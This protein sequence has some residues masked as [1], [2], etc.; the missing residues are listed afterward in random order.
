M[1]ILFITFYFQPEPN[2]PMCLPLA[3]ELTKLGHDVEV[4]TGFPNYPGGK[5]YEGYRTKLAFR[6]TLEG[7]PIVRIP[8]YPSHDRSAFRRVASYMSF[9][10]TA[11]TL[12]L[13]LAKPADAA[14]VYQG[15]ITL[16]LPSLL[17]KVLRSVPFVFNIQ[18]LWPDTLP[19]TGMF[20]SKL[21]L[22]LVDVW[23]NFVYKY[24]SKIVVISPGF[25]QKLC[26][27]GVPN[28]KVEVI[29]NWCDDTLIHPADPSPKLRKKLGLEN[30][31]NIVFAGNMGKAQA[32]HAILEAANIVACDCPRVQFVFVGSG[33]EEDFLK[34]KAADMGLNNVLFIE[35]QP[36]SE[37]GKILSLA[38]VLVVHLKDEPLFRITVPGKT[39]AYLAVGRPILIG[40]KGNAADLVTEAKAGLACAP[41]NPDSIAEVV[42]K[43]AAMSKDQLDAMG[44]SGRRFYEQEISL[45]VGTRKF[46]KIFEAVAK[47]P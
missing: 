23:C 44:A 45:A 42:R 27:R 15:P 30:R 34:Q 17:F 25:K 8:L 24:A 31:F 46:E 40:V 20:H 5:I 33:I 12:G 28:D 13:V 9:A 41:E 47:K 19:A 37:I 11:S 32:L 3:R 14:F 2:L 38:D 22:K 35:R 18:D 10:F 26:E 43:F 4:I 16:G 36:M 29:Y 7:V 21:G 39:Q 6:E 1:R